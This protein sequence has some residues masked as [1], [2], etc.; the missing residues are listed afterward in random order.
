MHARPIDLQALDADLCSLAPACAN[1]A[2]PASP[3]APPLSRRGRRT[4]LNPMTCGLF[5]MRWF[6]ISRSTFLSIWEGRCARRRS[7]AAAVTRRAWLGRKHNRALTYSHTADRAPWGR[8][9]LP[10]SMNFTAISSFVALSRIRRATP[11]LPLPMSR[12]CGRRRRGQHAHSKHTRR[13]APRRRDHSQTRSAPYLCRYSPAAGALRSVLR[14]HWTAA[15]RVQTRCLYTDQTICTNV[16]NAYGVMQAM[17][18]G[19]W[20]GHPLGAAERGPGRGAGVCRRE[21]LLA[22]RTL[23]PGQCLHLATDCCR[24]LRTRSSKELGGQ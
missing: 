13:A 18:D 20:R 3:H 15:R 24:F 19:F 6:S 23:C 8:T 9:L 1:Q 4:S 11:K 5:S 22:D 10:L 21:L 7:R 2:P 12:I 17:A 14:D 16:L